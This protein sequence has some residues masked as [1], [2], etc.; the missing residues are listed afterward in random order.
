MSFT[1][2]TLDHAFNVYGLKTFVFRQRMNDMPVRPIRKSLFWW[3]MAT[4]ETWHPTLGYFLIL[5]CFQLQFIRR[6]VKNKGMVRREI[7]NSIVETL[8]MFF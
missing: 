2:A 7:F 1:I 4:C 3:G 8:D 6:L 5:I